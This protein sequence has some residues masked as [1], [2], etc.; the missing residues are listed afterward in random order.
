MSRSEHFVLRSSHVLLLLII[1]SI[2]FSLLNFD[3]Y[4]KGGMPNAYQTISSVT[5]LLLWFISAYYLSRKNRSVLIAF[6]CYLGIGALLSAIGY[7]WDIGLVYILTVFLYAGPVYGVRSF[8]GI[9]SDIELVQLSIAITYI[10]SLL[11][12]IAGKV[13]RKPSA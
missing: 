2:P 7:F 3:A 4:L 10:A 13:K 1:L 5:F 6:S 8:I 9:P 11:G 12:W